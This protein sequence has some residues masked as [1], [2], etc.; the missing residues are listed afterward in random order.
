MEKFQDLEIHMSKDKQ[1][2]FINSIK[3][4][5]QWKR[6]LDKEKE[7]NKMSGQRNGFIFNKSDNIGCVPCSVF[8]FSQDNKLIIGN[9]VPDERFKNRIK[10]YNRCLS[11]F[12]DFISAYVNPNDIKV[13]SS[14]FNL[15]DYISE[16]S[17][18]NL[19]FFR[20][21]PTSL[22]DRRIQVIRNVGRSLLFN[23]I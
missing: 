8:L 1:K 20:L 3:D 6:D 22:Q 15:Q 16:A 7:L 17:Q 13:T 11:N 19:E 23:L 10:D 9:I 14:I 4:N 21:Q 2:E 12:K 18:K 5:K